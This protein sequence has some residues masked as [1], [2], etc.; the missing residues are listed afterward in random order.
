MGFDLYWADY[1]AAPDDAPRPEGAYFRLTNTGMAVVGEEMDA[2][3]M[4]YHTQFPDFPSWEDYEIPLDKEGEFDESSQAFRDYRAACELVAAAEDPTRRGIPSYK[5][6]TCDDWLVTPNEIESALAVASL[7][8]RVLRSEDDSQLW[9]DWL[10]FL[11][12]AKRRG[13]VRVW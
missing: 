9:N 13:G 8:P 10:A 5:F 3:G 12:A 1:A 4:L 2:Q 7:E 11:R 6:S